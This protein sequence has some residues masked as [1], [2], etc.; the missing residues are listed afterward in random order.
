MGRHERREELSVWRRVSTPDGYGGTTSVF[1]Q[2]GTVYAKVSQ[3]TAAEQV[4]AQQASATA[5]M[6]MHL[7]PD[8][9]V[10]RGDEL[11][12][13]DGTRLRVKW[14]IAPSEPAYLRADCELIQPEGV[15]Q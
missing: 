3:P 7:A 10:Y 9:Q 4:E 8:A 2:V 14:T 11:R 13:P 5:A 15:P 6:T 12:R 1:A